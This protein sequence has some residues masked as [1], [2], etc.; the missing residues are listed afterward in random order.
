MIKQSKSHYFSEPPISMQQL[1]IEKELRLETVSSS[2]NAQGPTDLK[3]LDDK[4]IIIIY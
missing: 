4:L 3:S 1:P 2:L